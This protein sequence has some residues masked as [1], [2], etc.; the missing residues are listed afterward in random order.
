MARPLSQ[1]NRE[2][3]L[4]NDINLNL[5]L[6]WLGKIFLPQDDQADNNFLQAAIVASVSHAP[7]QQRRNDSEPKTRQVDLENDKS[8]RANVNKMLETLTLA[9]HPPWIT[10]SGHSTTSSQKWGAS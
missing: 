6:T 10:F 5:L 3:E 9:N 8:Q 2:I 1:M 4:D 7:K